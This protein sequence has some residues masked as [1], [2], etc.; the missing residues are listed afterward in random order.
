MWKHYK[1]ISL[2]IVAL[3]SIASA[4]GGFPTSS[5]TPMPQAAQAG[6][7]APAGGMFESNTFL[8]MANLQPLRTTRL[9]LSFRAFP[10]CITDRRREAIRPVDGRYY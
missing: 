10:A 5:V 3:A 4:Q 2:G 1:S 8:E 6:A 7:S 9:P